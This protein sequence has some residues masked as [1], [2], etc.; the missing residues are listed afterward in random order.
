MIV[1][2]FSLS[3][4]ETPLAQ[5]LGGRL[6]G[7]PQAPLLTSI[8]N[9]AR[10]SLKLLLSGGQNISPNKWLRDLFLKEDSNISL[11]IFHSQPRFEHKFGKKKKKKK[12][13]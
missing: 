2:I 1:Y 10:L 8:S 13:C 12:P 4:L 5:A 6:N 11:M 3:K 7:E 9:A